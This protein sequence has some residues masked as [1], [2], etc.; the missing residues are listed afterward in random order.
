MCCPN[1]YDPQGRLRTFACRATRVSPFRMMVEVPV[2]GK[3]GDSLTS[4][5]RDFGHFEGTISDTTKRGLLLELEMTRAMR[6]KLAE[7]LALAGEKDQ[8]PL[9]H[10]RGPE[11]SALRS[12]GLA[13]HPDARRG[14]RSCV[15]HHRR[16]AVGRC[17]DGRSPAADRNAACDRRLHW[18]RHQAFSERI[19]RQVRQGA[20]PRRTEPPDRADGAGLRRAARWS[21]AQS[22]SRSESRPRISLRCIR[23]DEI[24]RAALT[25]PASSAGSG[26]RRSRPSPPCLPAVSAG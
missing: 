13:I 6:A 10:Q 1:W 23:D 3:V 21:A 16:L 11:K 5:F 12:K 2:V 22:G 7:K 14:H 20:K 18:P 15:P 24:L 26:R 8:G 4:Y 19:R 9:Q 25:P 17:R